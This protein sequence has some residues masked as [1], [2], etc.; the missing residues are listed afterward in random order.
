MTNE[1]IHQH[2][3]RFVKENPEDQSFEN[4][5][6]KIHP[7]SA[8]EDL[9]GFGDAIIDSKFYYSDNE[10]LKYWNNHLD[11]SKRSPVKGK[12][13]GNE[14][15]HSSPHMDLLS[16]DDDG[17]S[18]TSPSSLPKR[19]VKISPGEDLMKFD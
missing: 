16:G 9:L 14:S 7:E 19:T 4:W 2:F 17:D 12:T 15:D 1:Q 3:E 11:G 5:I 6:A 18:H 13:D 8:K 10:Y